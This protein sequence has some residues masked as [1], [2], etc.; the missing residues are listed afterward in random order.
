MHAEE[1][2]QIGHLAFVN[3]VELHELSLEQFDL[4]KLF[5]ALTEGEHRGASFDQGPP[6]GM[7]PV[8][9]GP[10]SPSG[11]PLM[12]NLI[13]SEIL[14]TRSTQVW[15]WMILPAVALTSLTSIGQSYS[16]VQDYHNGISPNYY[17]LFTASANGG[18]ALLV[19]GMLGL[20]TEFRHKTITPTLLA[21]PNRWLLLA[22][23]SIAYVMFA[24][25]YAVL[26]LIVNF[27]IAMIWLNAENVPTDFGHGVVPGI[28]K[29]FVSLVLI[30]IFG[31]GLGALVRNQA[32]AMVIGI[33]YFSIIDGLLSVIPWERRV[34]YKYTPGAAIDAFISNGHQQGGPDD[35][36]LFAPLAGGAA[37]PGLDAAASWSPAAT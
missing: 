21:T 7:P 29:A 5:F 12:L 8:Q 3:N 33:F 32:A 36:H 1:L 30:A 24:L 28:I 16:V 35:V 18:V 14:K 11:G 20:T 9:A 22:G 2:T 10:N 17:G 15:L 26:C 25:F 6:P 19:I 13:K 37:V 27:V 34:I 23:K 4:E 31:L